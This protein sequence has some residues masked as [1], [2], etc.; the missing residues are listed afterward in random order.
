MSWLPLFTTAGGT[1]YYFK[2]N[3]DGTYQVSSFQEV[4]PFL[5]RNVAMA[6]HN[7]GW[8]ASKDLRRLASVPLNLLRKWREEEGFDALN[9]HHDDVLKRKLN[10]IDF[11]KLRTAHWRV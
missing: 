4:D 3:G 1:E 9:P 5:D 10:D 8:S 11:Q 2:D 7:D 6:N